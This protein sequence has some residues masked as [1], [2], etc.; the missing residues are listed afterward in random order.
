MIMVKSLLTIVFGVFILISNS[1]SN[2]VMKTNNNAL[3]KLER[4][5][6]ESKFNV[7]TSGQFYQGLS[8]PEL[9]SKLSSFLN[10]SADDFIQVVKNQPT[11]KKFQDKIK[12][13]LGRFGPYYLDLDTEDREKVCYYLKN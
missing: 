7:E 3:I 12:I 13:G 1:Q 5:K 6:K 8:K 11:E 9:R 10:S 2:T 4:F